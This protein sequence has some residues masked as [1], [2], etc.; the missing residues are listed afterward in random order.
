LTAKL[1]NGCIKYL[2]PMNTKICKHCGINFE[3]FKNAKGFYCSYLCYF[4]QKRQNKGQITQ[5]RI[6]RILELYQRGMFIKPIACEVRTSFYKVK[7]VLQK[8]GIFDASRIR[9]QHVR[10]NKRISVG[11]LAGRLI[12][13]QYKRDAQ[14][15][16]RFD[17]SK[18]WENHPEMKRWAANKTARSQ[19]YKWRS[20]PA[21]LIRRRLRSRVNRVLTGKLKS[22]PTLT[23]LGCSLEQFKSHLESQFTRGMNWKNY[24]RSWHIDHKEPCS[25]FNLSNPPE[26]RRCFH[27][28]NLRPLG[29]KE[30]WSKH[31]R[32]IPTQRELLINLNEPKRSVIQR[33]F[34]KL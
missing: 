2:L 20:C 5:E 14:N 24:G 3:P 10:G 32:I 29:A 31:A 1:K 33:S 18:H 9:P 7:E 34:D 13:Q 27:Y 22:A 12:V 23:L 26:Q 6:G 17:E 16:K 8:A 4:A 28:S 15:L 11:K 21:I 19:Y 30:N 25:S